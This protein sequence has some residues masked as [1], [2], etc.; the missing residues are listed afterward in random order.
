MSIRVQQI[1]AGVAQNLSYVLSVD[2]GEGMVIDP[3]FAAKEILRVVAQRGISVRYIVD[4]HGHHDHIEGNR[5]LA[6]RTGGKVAIH[7]HD[8][9][10]L[11]EPPDVLLHD[12]DVLSMGDAKVQVIHTPGHTPG[13]ICLLAEGFLFTGD[14]LFVGNCGRTDL[15]GGS[16]EELFNS[17][18][19]LKSVEGSVKVYPGHSYWG[20]SSTIERERSTNPAMRCETL[21]EFRL[22]P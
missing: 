2:S 8:A 3:S 17:L 10:M 7:E 21:A 12:G 19:R 6:E 5:L 9:P 4:T 16:D 20:S 1:G 11:E 13:G 14:T 22:I 18:K 15:K